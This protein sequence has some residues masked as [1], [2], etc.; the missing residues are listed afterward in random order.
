MFK[1]IYFWDT[2]FIKS[3][4]IMTIFHLGQIKFC[5]LDFLKAQK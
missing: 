3:N 1:N 5:F 2:L 4:W